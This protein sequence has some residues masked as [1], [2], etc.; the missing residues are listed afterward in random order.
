LDCR[1]RAGSVPDRS[2]ALAQRLD[3]RV[4][5]RR[6]LRLPQQPQVAGLVSRLHRM[7]D[8]GDYSFEVFND[9]YQQM[10]LGKVVER[11]RRRAV[12]L[13]E[14]VLKRSALLP[15]RMRLRA[16]LA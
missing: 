4:V 13:A 8:R 3:L 2:K 14:D 15:D 11:A 7:G 10:P 9:D 6:R 16:P 5:Q 1:K 12:W